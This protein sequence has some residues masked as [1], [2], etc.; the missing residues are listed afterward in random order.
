[1]T[2]LSVNPPEKDI[3]ILVAFF[4]KKSFSPL[5]FFLVYFILTFLSLFRLHFFY[6]HSCI[7]FYFIIL[8]VLSYHLLSLFFT[9]FVLHIFHI[10]L[11]EVNFAFLYY[12]LCKLFKICSSSFFFSSF[13]HISRRTCFS[14]FLFI[15]KLIFLV[16]VLHSFLYL[17]FFTFSLSCLSIVYYSSNFFPQSISP[18]YSLFPL[19][20]IVLFVHILSSLLSCWFCFERPFSF[21]LS[22]PSPSFLVFL[23]NVCFHLDHPLFTF[24][25]HF[26]FF[27]VLSRVAFLLFYFLHFPFSLF[28]SNFSSR[29]SSR[30]FLFFLF[31]LFFSL[32]FPCFRFFLLGLFPLVHT[33][34]AY[35]YPSF[36]FTAILLLSILSIY[37][38][39]SFSF[40]LISC[41]F[42][43]PISFSS[44][45]LFL[46]SLFFISFI[47]IFF[48]LFFFLV[49]P[50]SSLSILP[51][52]SFF[53]LVLLLFL[54]LLFLF[55][56]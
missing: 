49:H 10:L 53:F 55:L 26:S 12:S 19:L 16:F 39:P 31:S 56:F 25:S 3:N 2:E 24:S 6:D 17:I 27:L 46:S 5:P 48:F 28:F 34:F 52:I 14:S 32:L 21:P 18:F 29:S 15:W 1:M 36:F 33:L 23:F 8:S 44:C 7:S 43:F 9:K 37:L 38:Y 11:L 50:L 45:F 4:L 30:L 20:F 42:F 54:P 40:S 47:L 35:L 51:P 22:S 41:V 13:S